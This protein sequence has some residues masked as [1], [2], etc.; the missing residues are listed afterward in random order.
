M[1]LAKQINPL[2]NVSCQRCAIK[3]LCL[4]VSLAESEIEY[5][6][7]I[8]HR[9]RPLRKDNHL[10]RAGD[11]LTSLY[12]I[13][14]G[15]IKSYTISM[16]GEEQVTG[17]HLAGE[18]IGL[19][20]VHNG[21]HPS[22]AIALETTTVCEIPFEQLEELSSFIPGLRK[23]LLRVM[24][25][26]IYD[27]QSL[28]LLLN[29]RNAESRIAAF[30]VSLSSRCSRRGFSPTEFKLPMTRADAGNYLGLTI[31]TVSRIL[32]R[33]NKQG[34][35]QIQGKYLK[36]LDLESLQML[37]GGSCDFCAI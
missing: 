5:L 13:R 4:P 3:P 34:M 22:F 32:S 27:D 1:A 30:L 33:F 36:I 19:D 31:E 12:A 25:R 8:I 23:Q 28:M 14:S 16:D 9:N 20:A 2:P 37:A 15:S 29:K 7:G 24:S 18:V 21:N 11:P 6:D 17:F 35:I 10:F 26:E